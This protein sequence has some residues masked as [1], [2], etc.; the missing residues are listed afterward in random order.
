MQQGETQ[1][2]VLYN[3]V[4]LHE[5]IK[6]DLQRRS[7]MCRLIL[8]L[9]LFG[10]GAS[11]T[12]STGGTSNSDGAGI[13]SVGEGTQNSFDSTEESG[14]AQPNS[15]AELEPEGESS[16]EVSGAADGSDTE[17]RDVR[18]QTAANDDGGSAGAEA[19]AELLEA[20]GYEKD[21][22]WGA[23]EDLRLKSLRRSI[24]EQLSERQADAVYEKLMSEANELAEKIDGFDLGREL[25]DR[26]FTSLVHAGFSIEEA[27]RAVHF[28]EI[29]RCASELISRSA[30]ASAMAKLRSL[31]ERPEENGAAGQ[32]PCETKLSVDA[33]TGKGIRDILRRVESGAKVKF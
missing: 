24:E 4:R 12:G 8:D 10:E 22:P 29:M 2:T 11:G 31:G 14:S 17:R 32:A 21:D 26:R 15:A 23:L 6:I 7:F 13:A 27:W 1:Y 9:G 16:A 30:E 25:S 33:L 28:R 18:A 5:V 3:A 19:L 20:L